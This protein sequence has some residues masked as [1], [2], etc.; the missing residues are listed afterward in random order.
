MPYRCVVKGCGS[1][2][3]SSQIY[4]LK[5]PDDINLQTKSNNF[6]KQT[7]NWSGSTKAC[8]ICSKHFHESDFT[9]YQQFSSGYAR[10]LNLKCNVCPS[11][12]PEKKNSTPALSVQLDPTPITP[13]TSLADSSANL[14]DIDGMQPASISILENVGTSTVKTELTPNVLDV[15]LSCEE[16]NNLC[17]LKK[18]RTFLVGNVVAIFKE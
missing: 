17:C 16:I 1:C 13:S 6:V 7:R 9:N 11:I 14:F 3:I 5:Y 18:L 10:L 8:R 2:P 15:S 12:Y 4:L